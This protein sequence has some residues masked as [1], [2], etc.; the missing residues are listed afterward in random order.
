MW[1]KYI[2]SVKGTSYDLAILVI[3]RNT[4]LGN[5]FPTKSSG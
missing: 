5:C 1:T 2:V 3:A 4:D